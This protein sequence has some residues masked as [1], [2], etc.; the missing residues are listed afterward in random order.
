M[1]NFLLCSL[2]FTCFLGFISKSF[3]FEKPFLTSSSES[4]SS[5]QW[6]ARYLD[7]IDKETSIE[8]VVDF[9]FSVR[10]LLINEGFSVPLFSEIFLSSLEDLKSHNIEIEEDSF[11]IESLYDEI[12]SREQQMNSLIS[13][14][15]LKDAQKPKI[16]LAKKKKKNDMKISNGFA[17]GFCKA[18]GGALLCIIPHPVSYAVGGGLLVSGISDMVQHADDPDGCTMEEIQRQLDERQRIGVEN[19]SSSPNFRDLKKQELYPIAI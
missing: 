16:I 7:S 6:V 17:K 13:F 3:A 19:M 2:I 12:I 9:L 8:E 11:F 14:R 10:N 5:Y 1:K 4:S 18:L 15:S